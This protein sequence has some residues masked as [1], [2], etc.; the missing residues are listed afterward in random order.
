MEA[1]C[2]THTC[3]G[4]MYICVCAVQQHCTSKAVGNPLTLFLYTLLFSS[5]YFLLPSSSYFP[6]NL[7]STSSTLHL[8]SHPPTPCSSPSPSHRVWTC[9]EFSMLQSPDLIRDRHLDQI[10]M[11]CIY[12]MAKVLR[13][14]ITF[15]EIMR[16]Y[17]HQ[18]Q[19]KSHVRYTPYTRQ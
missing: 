2:T 1:M 11:C 4:Y 7:T 10:I 14:D 9:F 3:M 5:P 15:Q 13:L 17:R 19:A 6:P 8:S 12:V 16:Q 18:P